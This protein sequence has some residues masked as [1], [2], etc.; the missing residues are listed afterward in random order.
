MNNHKY[1]SLY[2]KTKQERALPIELSIRTDFAVYLRIVI[3]QMTD[4]IPV[5]K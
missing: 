3:E 2:A 1:L 5:A 4:D